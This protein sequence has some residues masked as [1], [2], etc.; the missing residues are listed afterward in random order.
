VA[1]AVVAALMEDLRRRYGERWRE[2]ARRLYPG[3]DL[4]GQADAD[5]AELQHAYPG[6][7]MPTSMSVSGDVWAKMSARQRALPMRGIAALFVRRPVVRRC[8]RRA[9]APRARRTH[10]CRAR[11]PG[12]EPD[13][14]H[15]HVARRRGLVRVLGERS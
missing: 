12:R 7:T 5:E 1:R 6:S 14:P 11:S 13:R 15:D 10:R 9:F 3:L 4:E 2:E 8:A